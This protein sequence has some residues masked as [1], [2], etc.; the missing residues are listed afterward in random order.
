M[1]LRQSAITSYFPRRWSNQFFP[2]PARNNRPRCLSSREFASEY[3]RKPEF[4]RIDGG[5]IEIPPFPP[6]PNLVSPLSN[7][8][9]FASFSRFPSRHLSTRQRVYLFLPRVS[10][11]KFSGKKISQQ[12]CLVHFP[13]MIDRIS[14]DSFINR[15]RDEAGNSRVR[16]TDRPKL[17]PPVRFPSTE[18]SLDNFT[19]HA[20]VR[21]LA[22]STRRSNE[23]KKKKK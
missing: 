5:K 20:R 18:F 19:G 21:T 8:S 10:A 1:R 6:L 17:I 14:A 4:C 3:N 16:Q 2:G 9:A 13:K 12:T 23:K 11:K 22:R 15:D 7:P